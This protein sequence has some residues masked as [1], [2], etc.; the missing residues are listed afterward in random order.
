MKIVQRGEYAQLIIPN[1]PLHRLCE[2]CGAERTFRLLTKWEF[3][4]LG[5]IFR[6][7]Y[8]DTNVRICIACDRAYRLS[9]KE[10][11]DLVPAYEPLPAKYRRR[12]IFVAL[13]LPVIV[14]VV[15]WN[16]RKYI[17]L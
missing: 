1:Q 10:M 5:Y 15:Y 16:L 17:G 11:R 12:V 9:S 3:K 2:A 4:H 14:Y 13:W 8:A 6:W 7:D